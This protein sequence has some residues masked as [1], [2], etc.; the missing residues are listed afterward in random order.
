MRKTVSTLLL[1]VFVAGAAYAQRDKAAEQKK[2]MEAM[3]RAG[4]PGDAHKKLAAMA[5]TYEAK[6]K[7]WMDPKTP[8]AESTG[9]AVMEMVLGGR[10]LQERFDG[11]MMGQPFSGIGYTG[12]DNIRQMYVGTWMDTVSTAAM[13]S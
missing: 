5:G 6:V 2:A 4:T 8:P 9:T 13:S 10:W 12:Y 1:L 7:M 3:M 11:S